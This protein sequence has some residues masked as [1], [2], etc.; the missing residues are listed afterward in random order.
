MLPQAIRITQDQTINDVV[1][2]EDATTVQDIILEPRGLLYG[3]VTDFDNGFGLDGATVSADNGTSALTDG[4]G[5]YEMYLDEGNYQVT[6]SMQ[7]YAPEVAPV[8]IDSG[9]SIQQDFAL[10]AA[11]S[12]V[13]DPI[14]AVRNPWSNGISGNGSHKQPA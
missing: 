8:S 9:Q 6:A 4:T 7:D 13:P 14:H 5:Y 11:I 12:V 2:S 1:V 10:L 3:F